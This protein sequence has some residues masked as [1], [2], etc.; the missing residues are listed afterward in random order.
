MDLRGGGAWT[1]PDTPDGYNLFPTGHTFTHCADTSRLQRVR[2]VGRERP[3]ATTAIGRRFFGDF[4]GRPQAV[5]VARSRR[6]FVATVSA[7]SNDAPDTGSNSSTWSAR[8]PS[9]SV[10][11][12]F[13]AGPSVC[14]ET[15]VPASLAQ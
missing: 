12:G 8:A 4:R 2:P 9:A 15:S 3:H 1:A 10:S 5:A 6:Q 11:P 13:G 7:W 14:R